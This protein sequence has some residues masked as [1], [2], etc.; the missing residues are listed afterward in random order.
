MRIINLCLLAITFALSAHA[1]QSSGTAIVPNKPEEVIVDEELEETIKSPDVQPKYPGGI[2]GLMSFLAQNVVYPAEAAKN[3]IQGRV[4]VQFVIDTRGNVS[5]VKI[6]K[7]VH[8]L[9]DE[10]AMRVTRELKGW[11]PATLNGVPVST[12]YVLPITFHAKTAQPRR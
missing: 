2:N 10:E 1:Q 3:N 4:L 5:N 6:L 12:W 11:I 7:S 8:P 9:L